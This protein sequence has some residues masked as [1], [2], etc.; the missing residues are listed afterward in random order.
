MVTG[1]RFGG[2]EAAE[3]GIVAE[4]PAADVVLPRAIEIATEHAGKTRGNLRAI[5]QRMYLDVLGL[6]RS[7]EGIAGP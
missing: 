7:S 1:K 2:I 4:A 3:K 6:L 5:K